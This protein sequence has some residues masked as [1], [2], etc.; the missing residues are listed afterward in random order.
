MGNLQLW[1]VP[2]HE[3]FGNMTGVYYKYAHGAVLVFDLARQETFNSV[4]AWK[5]DFVTRMEF[6]NNPGDD[7]LPV[8]VLGNKCDLPNM[9]VDR[10]KYNSYVND[11]NLLG[12]YETSARDNK[13]V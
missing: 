1:D 5:E 8:V 6:D 12:F 9:S 7:P 4:I 10:Q 3:R 13:D 11:N 2:G